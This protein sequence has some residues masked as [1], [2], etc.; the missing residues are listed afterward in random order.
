MKRKRVI[1][2]GVSGGLIQ[3]VKGIPD[4]VRIVVF[5]YDIESVDARDLDV[6]ENGE[7]CVRSIWDEQNEK[8]GES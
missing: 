2:I 7:V 8:G 4:D 1:A 5:D 6:D 3:W